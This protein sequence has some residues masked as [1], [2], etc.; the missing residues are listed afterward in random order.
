MP[1]AQAVASH[2]AIT[3]QD[4]VTDFE[5]QQ[6]RLLLMSQPDFNLA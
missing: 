1:S 6:N 3:M 5:Q 2:H 4:V